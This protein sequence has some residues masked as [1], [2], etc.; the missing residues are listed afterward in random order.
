MQD[1]LIVWSDIHDTGIP[2]IDQQ[3]RGIVSIINSLFFF[4]RH[5]QGNDI[6]NATVTMIGQYTKIHFVT[7]EKLLK[8]TGY[9]DFEAHKRLHE[10]LINESTLVGGQSLRNQ[11]PSEY[12]IFLRNWW[13]NHINKHD[14]EYVEHFRKINELSESTLRK[15]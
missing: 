11:D 14:H 13:L 1:L 9:P 15:G 2:I 3:H 6:L 12:L 4:M 5:K 7:E 8:S 10:Q